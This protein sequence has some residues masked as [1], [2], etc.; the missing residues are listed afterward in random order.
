MISLT[1]VQKLIECRQRCVD[2]E[3]LSARQ[4]TDLDQRDLC[5]RQQQ[6]AILGPQSVRV[7]K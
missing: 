2:L 5:P 1:Y 3:I 7:R 6:Y 4:S